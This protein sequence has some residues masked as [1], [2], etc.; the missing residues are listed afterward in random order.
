MALVTGILY[1][2][3]ASGGDCVKQLWNYKFELGL[4]LTG[5]LLGINFLFP[6]FMPDGLYSC[7]LILFLVSIILLKLSAINEHLRNKINRGGIL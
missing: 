6:G 1:N 5:I 3:V 7:M 4:T 2:I